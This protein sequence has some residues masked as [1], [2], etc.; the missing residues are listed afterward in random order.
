MLRIATP[1]SAAAGSASTNSPL[2]NAM[3]AREPNSP[4]CAVPTLRTTPIRGGASLASSAMWPIPRADSSRA[5]KSV[6][7]SARRAVHGCPSSLLND[8]GGATTDPSG[9]S[10]AE[11][12]SFV[13]VLPDDP[14]TPTTVRSWRAVSSSTDSRANAPSAV[15][16]AAPAPS[17][18]CSSAIARLE[19]GAGRTTTAGTPTG[20]AA[21]T[22][23]APAATASAACSWPSTLAPGRARKTLP[24]V[25]LRESNS[26]GPATSTVGSATSCSSP[27]T[28]SA[29]RAIESGITVRLRSW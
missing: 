11:M 6:S 27:P 10:T 2:A 4:R 3:A 17:G 19:C 12:R 9:R 29:M 15:S 16:T 1:P 22:T 18:S 20:R 5:R 23:A 25:T 21:R 8:P 28:I 7:A 14:V 24:G 13:D 26:T